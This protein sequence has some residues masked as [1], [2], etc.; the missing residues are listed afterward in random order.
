MTSPPDRDVQERGSRL[1]GVVALLLGLGLVVAGGISASA[2]LP[3][4]PRPSVVEPT[5]PASS[6]AP[7]TV[8]PLPDA[9]R[10]PVNGVVRLGAGTYRVPPFDRDLIGATVPGDVRSVLGAGADRTVL[11]MAPRVS[12]R[13]GDVPTR[14]WTTNQLSVLKVTGSP[15][16]SGFTLQ[17]TDQGHLYNGL[18]V[19]RTKDA[20]VRDVRVAQIPGNN[21]VPPGETFG[22]NDY[23][24][25]G[26]VYERVEV[27]GR[28]VGASGF[29]TN[30]SADVTVRNGFFHDQ[31]AAHGATF[32]RT[33]TVT[34]VDVEATRNGGA[35]LNFER[36]R[37]VIT[38]IRPLLDANA[39]ADLRIA[40]D[41]GSARFRIV[42]PV[43][44]GGRL[45]VD[46][47]AEYNGVPN[48]QRREDIQVLEQGVDRTATTLRFV[49]RG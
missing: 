7:G 33:D 14:A 42:D 47:P 43:L 27:D 45:T 23:R 20:R 13:A 22:I 28:G 46:L 48:R 36:D 44:R 4:R 6:I 3:Q 16:L 34:L 5:F 30:R 41:L 9:L 35:G 2:L 8:G 21:D 25:T 37:G 40:S 17:G 15:V 18:R 32:W 1:P 12:T 38:I 29:A 49:A 26:S 39:V 19:H 24:T 10:R 11:A 31:R